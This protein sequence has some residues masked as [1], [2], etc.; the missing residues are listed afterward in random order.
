MST[1]TYTS[2][3]DGKCCLCETA[4]A[5]T[6]GDLFCIPC[7]RKLIRKD[8]EPG[9][10]YLAYERVG[11]EEFTSDRYGWTDDEDCYDGWNDAWEEVDDD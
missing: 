3:P 9:R 2:L 1:Q 7:L 8:S 10:S 6:R 11:R 5:E 4:N